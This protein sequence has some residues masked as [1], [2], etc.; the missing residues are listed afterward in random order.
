ML[1]KTIVKRTYKITA[2]KCNPKRERDKKF[3]QSKF[4][5]AVATTIR[6]TRML[7]IIVAKDLNEEQH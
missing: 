4:M 2:R 7:S 1:C 5:F 6:I 3:T